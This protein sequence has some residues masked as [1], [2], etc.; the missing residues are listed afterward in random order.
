MTRTPAQHDRDRCH[1]ERVE[2]WFDTL[3][4]TT[5]V[6]LSVSKGEEEE[7]FVWSCFGKLSM[8]TIVHHDIVKCIAK[9]TY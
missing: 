6:T 2:G 9:I 7:R 3:T 1:P 8:T 5:G 4:M